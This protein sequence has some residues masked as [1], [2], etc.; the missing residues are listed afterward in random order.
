MASWWLD[1]TPE[2]S[3][4]VTDENL[5][6]INYL[7]VVCQSNVT[8]CEGV[9]D[10]FDLSDIESLD[11]ALAAAAAIGAAAVAAAVIIPLVFICCACILFCKCKKL[12]CFKEEE[13]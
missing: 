5:K 8:M 11:D 3:K 10:P 7:S 12:M 1:Y 9:K 13:V 4:D 2:F 6:V